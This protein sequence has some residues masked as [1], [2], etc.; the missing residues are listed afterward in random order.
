M[1]FMLDHSEQRG[2]QL[3][4]HSALRSLGL[5]GV[6]IGNRWL[7]TEQEKVFRTCDKKLLQDR[8]WVIGVLCIPGGRFL[9]WCL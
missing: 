1:T 9:S 3:A 7:S 4:E 6:R 8:Y 5:V 2:D